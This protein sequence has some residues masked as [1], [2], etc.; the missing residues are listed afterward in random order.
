MIVV[1]NLFVMLKWCLL[2]FSVLCYFFIRILNL[3]VFMNV[4]S[5]IGVRNN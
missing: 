2:H 1:R 4:F 5:V 3:S